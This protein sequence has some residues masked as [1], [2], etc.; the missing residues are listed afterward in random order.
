MGRVGF[1]LGQ[2]PA[3]NVSIN[4]WPSS[5]VECGH[6]GTGS[7]TSLAIA[8]GPDSGQRTGGQLWLKIGRAT[9]SVSFSWGVGEDGARPTTWTTVAISTD[10]TV[11]TRAS[12]TYVE[13]FGLTTTSAAVTA[14]ILDI[15]QGPPGAF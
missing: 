4:L 1:A 7:F 12:G 3:A 11:V 8:A 14:D 13:I 10:P 6:Y 5:N 15:Q 2:S 9:T